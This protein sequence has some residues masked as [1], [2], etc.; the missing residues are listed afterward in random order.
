MNSLKYTTLIIGCV[1]LAISFAIFGY[2]IIQ[3]YETD[4]LIT[5]STNIT[6]VKIIP[7]LINSNIIL[8]EMIIDAGECSNSCCVEE[9]N[10]TPIE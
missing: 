1:V 3:W 6:G 4:N 2:S 5:K 7:T 8:P 10:Y 9:E